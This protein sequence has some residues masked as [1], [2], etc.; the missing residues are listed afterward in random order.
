M[1]PFPATTK[2]HL[3]QKPVTNPF[4]QVSGWKILQPIANLQKKKKLGVAPCHFIHFTCT[5]QA[6]FL[7]VPEDHLSGSAPCKLLSYKLL[8][9]VIK[10]LTASHIWQCGR[11]W[12]IQHY[13]ARNF[14]FL[15]RRLA[16]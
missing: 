16:L 1:K 3:P 7:Y 9:Q 14:R 4:P 8:Y 6:Y 5:Q 2:L 10:A 15:V 13:L 12:Q 11:I